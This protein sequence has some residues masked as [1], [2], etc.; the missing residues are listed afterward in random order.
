MARPSFA[1]AW[2]ASIEIYDPAHPG[3]KVAQVIGGNVAK[4]INNSDRN[5]RWNNTCAVRMSYILIR[6]GMGAA[7]QNRSV[8]SLRRRRSGRQEGPD[9]VRD[10]R[11]DRCG[12]PCDAL[13]WQ[14]LL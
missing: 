9:P 10:F 5:Q 1:G 12:G 4:N 8:S 2:T 6:A 11:M 13:E 3:V 7:R 14:C